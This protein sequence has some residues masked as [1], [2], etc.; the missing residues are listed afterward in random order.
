MNTNVV[1]KNLKDDDTKSTFVIKAILSSLRTILEVSI[2]AGSLKG[3]HFQMQGF[4][5][6]CPFLMTAD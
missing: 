2:S 1:F 5:H 4:V 3:S 6:L